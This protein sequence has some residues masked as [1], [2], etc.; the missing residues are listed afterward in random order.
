MPTF[1]EACCCNGH[2]PAKV[3]SA[4]HYSR[5]VIIGK[6]LK[7]RQLIRVLSAPDGF[8]KSTIAYE[9]AS[10]M[11]SFKQVIWISC[12]SPCFLRDLDSET[13]VSQALACFAEP[14][15]IVFDDMPELKETRISKM[16]NV[17]SGF[18][19]AGSEVIV[20]CMPNCECMSRQAY[21]CVVFGWYELLLTESE[22]S[23]DVLSGRISDEKFAHLNT[24]DKIAGWV[25]SD[26]INVRSKTVASIIEN[27]APDTL[28]AT[29]F[30]VLVIEFGSIDDLQEFLDRQTLCLNFGRLESDYGIFGVDMNTETF[31]CGFLDSQEIKYIF[32]GHLPNIVKCCGYACV[33]DFV[34]AIGLHL[35]KKQN[36][37][38]ASSLIR[39]YS[40]H[41]GSGEWFAQNGW[42]YVVYARPYNAYIMLDSV[43]RDLS[44]NYSQL[45]IIELLTFYQL[46]D[47][48]NLAKCV[49]KILKSAKADNAS[50]RVAL[51]FACIY[52]NPSEARNLLGSLQFVLNN[53]P[54]SVHSQTHGESTLIER[55]LASKCLLDIASDILEHG[56]R[57]FSTWLKYANNTSLPFE[58]ACVPSQKPPRAYHTLLLAFTWLFS[59]AIDAEDTSAALVEKCAHKLTSLMTQKH[60]ASA[61]T[62]EISGICWFESCAISALCRPEI[63]SEAFLIQQG[64]EADL[65]RAQAVF[66]LLESQQ[67]SYSAKMAELVRA[68]S[69][70]SK[71]CP[72]I[73]RR[74]SVNAKFDQISVSEICIPVLAVNLFGGFDVYI[75]GN[76]VNPHNFTREK[77]RILLAALLIQKGG[78]IS[79][80]TISE[81]LW[82]NSSLETKRRNFYSVF[83]QLRSALKVDSYCPYLI[84]SKSGIHLDLTHVESDIYTFEKLYKTLLFDI[85][86]DTW[87]HYYVEVHEHY[88][89][90]IMPEDYSCEIINRYRKHTETML[91]D[92]LTCA[93]EN[94]CQAGCPRGALMFAREALVHDSRREDCYVTLMKSQMKLGQQAGALD[95]FFE[96]KAFLNDELGIDPS[97]ELTQLYR[98]IIET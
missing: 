18:M 93:S 1:I 83:S 8:G 42:R 12:K 35:V 45:C 23:I 48:D 70:F 14:K 37:E 98:E 44:A 13:I 95:T 52:F 88:A 28:I 53:E 31:K 66:E 5:P 62:P 7:D 59:Y 6:L 17:L 77:V 57:A 22:L 32:A 73:F 60:V 51:A 21:N 36:F 49:R 43:K 33:D 63:C 4:K 29:I 34:G 25:W 15:L 71:S 64:F 67:M 81:N 27:G 92:A 89:D 76:L 61:E 47:F 3:V 11:F 41:A 79:R 90:S 58:H 94:L 84:K 91:V 10:M 80:D 87:R 38:A 69:E 78:E 55:E 97:A 96:C 26:D 85:S 56:A 65:T 19:E 74:N 75:G 46:K 40:T 68:K 50:K 20:T 24:L 16:M 30:L 2:G 54:L 39:N 86:A 72:D 9:Y 82:P